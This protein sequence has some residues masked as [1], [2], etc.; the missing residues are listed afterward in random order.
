MRADS[1]NCIWTTLIF[2]AWR[3]FPHPRSPIDHFFFP[4]QQYVLE[5]MRWISRWENDQSKQNGNKSRSHSKTTAKGIFSFSLLPRR[6]RFSR[7]SL[8]I[9]QRSDRVGHT[10]E[11]WG[12]TTSIERLCNC[13]CSCCWTKIAEMFR[14]DCSKY[15]TK[16]QTTP[17]SKSTSH[18]RGKRH[19]AIFYINHT[20]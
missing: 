3:C 15:S 4:L 11:Q 14:S 12:S 10:T 20:G 18:G 7:H 13:K 6:N 2:G 8:E 1:T 16:N 9:A 19:C 17:S 5:E